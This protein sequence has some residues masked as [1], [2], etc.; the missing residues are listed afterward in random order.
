MSKNMAATSP[1]AADAIARIAVKNHLITTSQAPEI[2]RRIQNAPERDE[3]EMLA[4]VV[5]F[6]PEQTDTL[7]RKMIAQRA[8]RT[9]S[10]ERGL[11]DHP[12]RR[13]AGGEAAAVALDDEADRAVL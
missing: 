4:E 6:S 10:L 7:R 1:M 11:W 9:F 12:Q 2:T 3:V 13:D 5:R 8:A